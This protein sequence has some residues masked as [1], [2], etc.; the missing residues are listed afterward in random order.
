M[1][2][3]GS[4]RGASIGLCGDGID[5]DGNGFTDCADLGC[6]VGSGAWIDPINCN[7]AAT[8]CGCSMNLP[9]AE[10]A[11]KVTAGAAPSPAR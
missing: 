3:A 11:N 5:N 7:A 6:E 8:T 4:Q 9:V 1:P 10:G 2:A